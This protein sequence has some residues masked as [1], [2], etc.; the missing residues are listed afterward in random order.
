M[1]VGANALAVWNKD[2]VIGCGLL[3]SN[4]KVL[5]NCGES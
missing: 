2:I 3:L 4:Q 5:M 1:H